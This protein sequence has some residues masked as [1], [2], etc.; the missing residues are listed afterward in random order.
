MVEGVSGTGSSQPIQPPSNEETGVTEQQIDQAA[1]VA[2]SLSDLMPG[3][4]NQINIPE[5]S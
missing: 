3:I 4:A 1:D 5:S 2:Q